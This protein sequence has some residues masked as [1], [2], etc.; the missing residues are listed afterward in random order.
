WDLAA[1]ALLVREAGGK[2]TDFTGKDWA[3]GDS[4]IL[5][6]NGTQTHEEVL[7]ILWQK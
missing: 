6:S 1:G 5:V 2:A 3:P 4:N 7:K